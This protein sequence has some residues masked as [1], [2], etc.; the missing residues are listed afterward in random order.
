LNEAHVDRIG[1]A[2]LASKFLANRTNGAN[3]L[4]ITGGHTIAHWIG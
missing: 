1:R 2:D 4:T 3:L